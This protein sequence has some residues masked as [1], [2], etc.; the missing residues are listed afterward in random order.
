VTT[1]IRALTALIRHRRALAAV[2]AALLG[3]L[4]ITVPPDLSDFAGAAGLLLRGRLGEVYAGSWNQAGPAQL[5]ISRLLST[6]AAPDGTPWAPIVMLVDAA[7]VVAAMWLCARLTGDDGPKL[8]RREAATGLF[9]LLWVAAPM[10]W[11]GHPAEIAIPVL[12]AY[13]IVLGRRGR[14]LAAAAVLALGVAIAPWAILGLPG[15]LAAAPPPR[16]LRTAL[17]GVALGVAAYLPF[18]LTG[19]FA[20]FELRWDVDAGTIPALL[21]I[22]DVSWW[23]R[24]VQAAVVAAVV[25][26][27]AW[28]L[29]AEP[30]AV[31]AVP[32]VAALLRIATDPVVHPYYWYPVAAASLLLLAMIPAG[33]RWL[34]AA[35]LG[36]LALLGESADWPVAAP[37]GCLVL[38]APATTKRP[39]GSGATFPAVAATR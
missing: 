10:P 18:V 3:L 29:R 36:L 38:L 22:H 12:W 30:V 17:L 33:P 1:P 26:L 6:G 23:L 28:R 32:L 24:P 19:H 13:P 25:A 9:A 5:L 7:L 20:M 8:V 31:A 21:G 11:N 2:L 14:H 35:G 34:L 39:S 16:A 15:L 27:T 37:I 4:T